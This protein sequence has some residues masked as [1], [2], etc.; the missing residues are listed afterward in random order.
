MSKKGA[1]IAVLVVGVIAFFLGRMGSTPGS[2]KPVA[3]RRILYYVDPMHPS[4]HSDK[5]GT[6]P[7]CG[8]TL[9]PVYEGG[10][11][12]AGVNLPAGTL[13]V[14]PEVQQLSGV[15]VEA[16]RDSAAKSWVRTSGRVEPQDSRVYRITFGAEGWVRSVENIPE[17]G[18]VKKDGVLAVVYAGGFLYPEQNYINALGNEASMKFQARY[19]RAMGM[20]E[21]QLREI[22]K[23]RQTTEEIAVTS[24]VDGILL[25]R[26]ISPDQRFDKGMELYRIADLSKV[27]IM[28]DIYGAA[29]QPL[30]RGASVKVTA[31][32]LS[33]NFSA[34]VSSDSLS[35]DPVSRTRK[36]RLEADNPGLLLRPDMYVEVEFQA[37]AAPGVYIPKDAVLDSG[38]RKIVYVEKRKGLFEPRQIE[39]GELH[40][41]EVNVKRGLSAGERVATSGA[42]LLDSESK[43]RL[44]EAS[45]PGRDA[46]PPRQ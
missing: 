36:V 11:S 39:T 45:S 1:F 21:P 23:T 4:Y 32:E 6:A 37:K 46:A 8:M 26:A 15:R 35:F 7:D 17:G 42:F 40:G 44:P 12:S 22:A 27:W 14:G 33:K 31:R 5:P 20:G 24:P 38:L 3:T 43:L 10:V 13:P 2:D 9:E 16:A 29:T 25:S 19:L 41:D 34:V 30:R 18:I 28:A